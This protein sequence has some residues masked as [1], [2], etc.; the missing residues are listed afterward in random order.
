MIGGYIILW[1]ILLLP[2][3][4][5]WVPFLVLLQ[6][7]WNKNH[8]DGR[9]VGYACRSAEMCIRLVILEFL[10]NY[11]SRPT[12][13]G[14]VKDIKK[15]YFLDS[16]IFMNTIH[17][18]INFGLMTLSN[19]QKQ[20]YTSLFHQINGSNNIMQTENK[21]IINYNYY[22]CIYISLPCIMKNKHKEVHM[23]E[24]WNNC[25][26]LC[27]IYYDQLKFGTRF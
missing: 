10:N 27:I 13:V 9:D 19:K 25:I 17:I 7:L 18:H 4:I 15:K 3:F 6:F 2:L 24:W 23:S 5:I 20:F 12:D 8:N 26:S 21:L 16:S 11:S 22:I 14:V 1:R